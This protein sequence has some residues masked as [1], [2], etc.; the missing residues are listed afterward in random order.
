MKGKENKIV[1]DYV[2]PDYT[3]IKRGYIKVGKI[4]IKNL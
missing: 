2:L 4:E 3:N 1:R